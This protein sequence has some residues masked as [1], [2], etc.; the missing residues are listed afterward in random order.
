MAL[1]G[2]RQSPKLW[3]DFRDEEMTKMEA[4]CGAEKVRMA[5]MLTEPNLWRIVEGEGA[6]EVLR[7]V[8][9][10]YVDDMLFLGEEKYV[11]LMIEEVRKKWET[12]VPEELGEEVGVRFLGA[13]LW[14]KKD[15]SI[16]ATQSSYIT[17]PSQEWKKK[18]VPIN[19]EISEA[20][21]EEINAALVKQAQKVVGELVWLVT[22]CRPDLMF[23]TSK[24]AAAITKN[25]KAVAEAGVHVWAYLAATVELCV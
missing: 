11:D 13:E 16:Q 17:E 3:G 5:Q 18:K 1:Y 4:S 19:K 25:P 23:S 22:R 2:Y 24:L 8:V 10:V 7:G 21:P 9:V 12:S 20:E 14:R 15:G 6:T